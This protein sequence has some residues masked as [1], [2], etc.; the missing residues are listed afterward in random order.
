MSNKV[1]RTN[2]SGKVFTEIELPTVDVSTLA[3]LRPG[4]LQLDGYL[5]LD[6]GRVLVSSWVTGEVSMFSPSGKDR[7][8]VARWIR[9]LS[10]QDRQG[11]PTSLWTS[12][13]TASSFR[14]STKENF[15]SFR[16]PRNE[17]MAAKSDS[18]TLGYN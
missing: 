1:L 2:P 8:V 15:A 4:A 10:P 14:S 6:D 7:T 17:R 9:A 16:F 13:E 11:L 3:N 12:P 18:R 5:R